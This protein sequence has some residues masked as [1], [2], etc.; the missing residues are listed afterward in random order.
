MTYQ[1]S[2]R[3]LAYFFLLNIVV[4]TT[5]FKSNRNR[6]Q[7]YSSPFFLFFKNYDLFKIFHVLCVKNENLHTIHFNLRLYTSK[8]FTKTAVPEMEIVLST[9][10]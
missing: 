10:T 8:E 3:K 7:V 9:C 2:V 4:Y 5:Y 6:F 1:F